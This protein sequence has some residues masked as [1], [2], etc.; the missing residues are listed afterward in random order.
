MTLESSDLLWPTL[1]ES[2]RSDVHI[3]RYFLQ[4][5]CQCALTKWTT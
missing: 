3:V 4:I 2:D 5:D 1:T